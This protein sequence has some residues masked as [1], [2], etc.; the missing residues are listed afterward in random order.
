MIYFLAAKCV[1]GVEMDV[2]G[3]NVNCD[4]VNKSLRFLFFLNAEMILYGWSGA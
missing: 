4:C 3:C 1:L 2:D